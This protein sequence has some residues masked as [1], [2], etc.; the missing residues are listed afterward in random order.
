MKQLTQGE[1][2]VMLILWEL[3]GGLTKDVLERMPEPRVSYNTVSTTLR[4]LV[5][6]CVAQALPDGR[7]HR[8]IPLFTKTEYARFLLSHLMVHF[9][10]NSLK[11]LLELCVNGSLPLKDSGKKKKKDKKKKKKKGEKHPVVL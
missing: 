7:N 1:E 6:K 3:G 8:Y 4:I 10:E 11:N 5:K 9:C 2:Q